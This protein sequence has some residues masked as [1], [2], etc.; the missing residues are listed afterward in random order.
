MKLDIRLGTRFF[1]ILE[2]LGIEETARMYWRFRVVEILVNRNPVVI[3]TVIIL[4]LWLN[5]RMEKE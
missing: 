1:H 3:R 4:C 2:I 5:K